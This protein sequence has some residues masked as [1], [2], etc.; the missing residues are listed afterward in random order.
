MGMADALAA[1]EAARAFSELFP[2]VYL[3][4]HVRHGGGHRTLTPQSWAVLQHLAM[5]GPLTISEAARHLGRA[6]S[7]TSEIME[8]LEKKGLVERMR[9]ARDRRRTLVWLTDEAHATMADARRV[10]DGAR[11]EKAMATMTRSECA[12]LVKGMRALVRA[13]GE[14]DKEKKR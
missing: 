3:R 1:P 7:V 2:E 4:Y 14:K 13:F 9:D 10:L 6:Q 8:G 12:A 5:G 11:L